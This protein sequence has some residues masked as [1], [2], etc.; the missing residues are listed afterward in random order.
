MYVAAEARRAAVWT[1]AR[2]LY[3]WDPRE[4][5]LDDYGNRIR[6]SDYGNRSSE[7]GWEIDHV[8]PRA[9]DGP[10]AFWNE[11]PLHWRA[12][13][14]RSASPLAEVLALAQQ[15]IPQRPAMPGTPTRPDVPWRR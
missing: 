14:R 4:W 6:F 8:I 11:R 1:K 10:S 5:R 2:L 15:S 12:N 9:M 13:A 7:Y 3:G